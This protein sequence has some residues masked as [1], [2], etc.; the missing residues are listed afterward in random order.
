[1]SCTAL[2]GGIN[3]DSN[4]G[5]KAY[6]CVWFVD[7]TGAYPVR[8]HCMGG[9]SIS[10]VDGKNKELQTIPLAD[11]INQELLYRFSRIRNNKTATSIAPSLSQ[12]YFDITTNEALV[13]ILDLLSMKDER[14]KAHNSVTVTTNTI[15]PPKTRLELVCVS[16]VANT[17]TNQPRR[18]M[19]RKRISD[20]WGM[21]NTLRASS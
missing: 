18:R 19:M 17:N 14:S 2:I 8:A 20:V 15:L 5:G 6:G 9:G 4:F 12:L 7:A 3:F 21:K 11:Y 13:M 1:L 16:T 10:V